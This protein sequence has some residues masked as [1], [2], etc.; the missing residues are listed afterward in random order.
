MGMSYLFNWIEAFEADVLAKKMS[1][2]LPRTRPRVIPGNTWPHRFMIQLTYFD[3]S[4]LLNTVVT[5][6][7]PEAAK[8]PA[9]SWYSAAF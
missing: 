2:E 9:D 3:L 6:L 1:F 7:R 8:R 4:I 5:R